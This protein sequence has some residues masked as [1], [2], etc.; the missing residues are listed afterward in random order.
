MLKLKRK[1]KDEK[2]ESKRTEGVGPKNLIDE[3]A[4]S[5]DPVQALVL[6]VAG[7][8]CRARGRWSEQNNFDL[9]DFFSVNFFTKR[10]VYFFSFLPVQEEQKDDEHE[11]M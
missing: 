5:T 6:H 4:S 2:T 10:K 7:A 1:M 3:G 9:F 8:P 11:G